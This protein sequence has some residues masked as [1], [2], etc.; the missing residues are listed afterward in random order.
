MLRSNC[1]QADRDT[2]TEHVQLSEYNLQLAYTKQVGRLVAHNAVPYKVTHIE[3][4]CP[5]S[6]E[7]KPTSKSTEHA[8]NE[9]SGY[10]IHNTT[11]H[12]IILICLNKE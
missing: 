2:V 3:I 1:F 10:G 9:P 4:H 12:Y 6:K 8:L 7:A 11:R 5:K